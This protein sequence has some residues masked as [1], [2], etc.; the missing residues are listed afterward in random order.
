MASMEVSE[1]VRKKLREGEVLYWTD[2]AP[3]S[4]KF[5]AYARWKDPFGRSQRSKT[6]SFDIDKDA[7]AFLVSLR[8][9][10]QRLV[11]R[12]SDR[13]LRD[14]FD[15]CSEKRWP[16][17][18]ASVTISNK[19]SR[20]KRFIDPYLGSAAMKAITKAVVTAWLEELEAKETP[21]SQLIEAKNDLFK[22]FEDAIDQEEYDRNPVRKTELEK[23][24]LRQKVV[25]SSAEIA[26]LLKQM[27]EYASQG[28]LPEW[29]VGMTACG[30]LAGLRKGEIQALCWG[31]EG[32]DLTTAFIN[33]NRSAHRNENGVMS[34]GLPKAGKTRRVPI[35]TQLK[36]VLNRLAPDDI[37]IAMTEGRLVFPSR[38]RQM[39]YPKQIK[40]QFDE[41]K[42]LCKLPT[43]MQFR[44]TRASYASLLDSMALGQKTTLELMGHESIQVTTERYMESQDEAKRVAGAKLGRMLGGKT[45]KRKAVSTQRESPNDE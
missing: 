23:P 11:G 30:L 38:R 4:G 35:P 18:I 19:K 3:H 36:S 32:V 2:K 25:L 21:P 20:W 44:D 10:Q 8:H 16:S 42:T 43:T 15:W 7:L 41:L 17:R 27:D 26:S 5:V 22:L 9:D 14:W 13:P 39:I 34:V 24:D 12:Y 28:V 1:A 29:I 37:D 31:T 33:V 6:R 45:T 40:E